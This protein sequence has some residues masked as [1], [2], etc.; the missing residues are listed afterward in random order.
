[1]KRKLVKEIKGP[2]IISKRK[3]GY[4]IKEKTSVNKAKEQQH[5]KIDQVDENVIKNTLNRKLSPTKSKEV[6]I[7]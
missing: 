1:M 5:F 6:T 7:I 4:S 2:M 3:N